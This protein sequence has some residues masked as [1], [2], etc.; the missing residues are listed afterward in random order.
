MAKGLINETNGVK[1]DLNQISPS[2][3]TESLATKFIISFSAVQSTQKLFR[4]EQRNSPLDGL[5]VV[6][7]FILFL[8]QVYGLSPGLVTARLQNHQ[9]SY[10]L[11]AFND[12]FY[13]FVRVPG[14]WNDGFTFTL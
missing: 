8:L 1:I 5:R 7:T 12:N 3:N 11:D 2:S 9:I 14:L 10:P 13:W 4:I 6:L